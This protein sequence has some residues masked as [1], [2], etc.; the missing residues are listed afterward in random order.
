MLGSKK[1]N[2]TNKPISCLQQAERESI[3]P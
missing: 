1:L 2:L 3:L